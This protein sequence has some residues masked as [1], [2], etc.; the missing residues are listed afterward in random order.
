M[1][2]GIEKVIDEKNELW[3][4]LQD[5]QDLLEQTKIEKD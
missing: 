3:K 5:V 1:E 2:G 4:A